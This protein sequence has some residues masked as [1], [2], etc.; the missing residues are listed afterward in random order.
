MRLSLVVNKVWVDKE[1]VSLI[2]MKIRNRSDT[3]WYRCGKCVEMDKNVEYLRWHKV[4]GMEYFELLHLKYDDTNIV[5]QRVKAAFEK[6][7]F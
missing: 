5:N 7:L 1:P 2:H 3:E 6:D 4:K